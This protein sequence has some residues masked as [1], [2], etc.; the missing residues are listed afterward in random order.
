MYE[1]PH[2][3]PNMYRAEK[4]WVGDTNASLKLQ[5]TLLPLIVWRTHPHICRDL[6]NRHK[7]SPTHLHTYISTYL[8]SYL[9]PTTYLLPTY[10]RTQTHTQTRTFSAVPSIYAI[11]RLTSPFPQSS[12]AKALIRPP[13][14][15]AFPE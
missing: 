11:P 2:N 13:R 7:W 6:R 5:S 8:P 4:I 1:S 15:K 10:L 12:L 9:L 14:R 3:P